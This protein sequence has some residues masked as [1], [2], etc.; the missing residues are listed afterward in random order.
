[1]SSPTLAQVIAAITPLFADDL[2][3]V[4]QP[5]AQPP[6]P[7]TTLILPP[8]FAG[9]S[10]VRGA[11]DG[12]SNQRIVG[13]F[14]STNAWLIAFKTGVASARTSR[15]AGAEYGSQPIARHYALIRASDNAVIDSS[16]TGPTITIWIGV[17]SPPAYGVQLD[18]G[19]DY[20]LAIRDAQAGGG[21]MY[22]DLIT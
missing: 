8:D 14:Y 6:A 22:M 7:A 20:Y 21:G 18:A 4:P 12:W 5:P 17:G 19:T 11:F 2:P 1:M 10:I 9:L 16:D 3:T 13:T 15:I